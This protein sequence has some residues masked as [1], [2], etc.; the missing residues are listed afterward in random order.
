MGRVAAPLVTMSVVVFLG[1]AAPAVAAGNLAAN[2]TN[3]ELKIDAVNLQL[4]QNEFD[5]ET[6]KYYH[7]DITVDEPDDTAFMAP[8][9]W[10]NVWID[11]IAVDD[12]EVRTQEPYSL[13]W[14]SAGTFS[15]SFVPIRPG[16][17]EFWIAG[18]EGRGLKGKF[19]VN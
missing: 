15:V 1:L 18:Y 6:G 12:L 17:Y 8:E 16:V 9:L 2:A 4:S 11:Q 13:E 10:R 19:V 5:L 3:L 14:G 7:I